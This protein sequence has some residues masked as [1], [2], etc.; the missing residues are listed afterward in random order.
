MAQQTG[1]AP[2]VTDLFEC[3][4]VDDTYILCSSL[5]QRDDIVLHCGDIVCLLPQHGKVDQS[6]YGDYCL[7]YLQERHEGTNA[8]S[9]G[10]ICLQAIQAASVTPQLLSRYLCQD[11]PDYLNLARTPKL[12]IHIV[13]S[14]L[15]G[16]GAA[17]SY[18]KHVLQPFFSHIEVSN[19]DVYETRTA[20]SIV[21]LCQSKIIPAAQEG[22]AQTIVFLSGDGGIVDTIDTFYKSAKSLLASPSIALIPMGTGNAMAS[23]LGL[24]AHRASGLANLLRGALKPMPTFSATFSPGAQYITHEGSARDPVG[25]GS[26]AH[27]ESPVVYGGVVASWGMHAS[28]VADSD[29]A[30]YRKHGAERFKMAAKELLYPS[31]GN[32][33]HK[34]MGTISLARRD[35]QTGAATEA[36]LDSE[37]HMYVLVTLVPKLE[38][39]FMVSPESLPLDGSLR[40]VHFA[41]TSPENAMRLMGCAYQGGQHVHEE[42][43]TYLEIEKLR[44][45]FC[46]PEERWRRVCIDGKIVAI[47]AGGWMEVCKDPRAM[48]NLLAPVDH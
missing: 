38:K 28:L 2:P 25:K 31:D 10:L 40:L 37:D 7:L 43:V 36:K 20:L 12:K 21:E 6:E 15:S 14:T 17:G 23:S 33:S 1:Y 47:E 8:D 42:G 30:E 24:L 32:E 16:I 27:F 19:Y 22:C 45:D 29:T 18:L 4:E 26:T 13:V 48:L 41:P 39:E 9:K 46:E 44:I 35:P 34:Y 11:V 3:S 5:H